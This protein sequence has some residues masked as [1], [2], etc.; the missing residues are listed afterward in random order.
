MNS[1]KTLVKIGVLASGSGTNAENLI[2]YFQSQQTCKIEVIVT[3]NPQAGVIDKAKRLGV[4]V[5]ILSNAE[6]AEGLPLIETLQAF[7]VEM[8]VLAGFLR[9]IAPV[10]VERWPKTILNL[11]PSLLPLFGGKGMYGENV[12]KAVLEAGVPESGITIHQVNAQYDEGHI[13]FQAKVPIAHGESLVSLA[14]KIHTLEYQHLPR[15]VEAFA[16][17]HFKIH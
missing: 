11:H 8:I 7:Q 4:A 2:R 17:E 13:L 1:P 6:I 12:H 5:R 16:L 15:V 9:K 10:V 3:N 14:Q